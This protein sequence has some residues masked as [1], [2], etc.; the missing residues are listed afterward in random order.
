MSR[1]PEAGAT[2]PIVSQRRRR[3]VGDSVLLLGRFVFEDIPI[4]FRGLQRSGGRVV[5]DDVDNKVA[6]PRNVNG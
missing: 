1:P 6:D 3:Q 2:F 5:D 4:E